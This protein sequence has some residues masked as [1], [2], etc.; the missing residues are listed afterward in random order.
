MFQRQAKSILSF[1]SLLIYVD[2]LKLLHVIS[3]FVEGEPGNVLSP[4]APL[5]LDLLE[6]W[7]DV[8]SLCRLNPFLLYYVS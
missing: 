5:M 4:K 3:F 6:A 7:L 2:T 1:L 8:R